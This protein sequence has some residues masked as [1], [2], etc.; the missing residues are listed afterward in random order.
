MRHGLGLIFTLTALS[1]SAC[2]MKHPAPSP[3]PPPQASAP[4]PTNT[5]CPV[6]HEEVDPRNP[7][8]ARVSYRGKSYAVCCQD[9]VKDFNA[10][11]AKFV[12]SE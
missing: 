10:N 3:V 4:A 1:L 9:C 11:P 12:K 2:C 8:L 7:K 5:L 6:S